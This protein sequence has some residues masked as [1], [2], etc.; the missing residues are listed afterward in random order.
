MVESTVVKPMPPVTFGTGPADTPM[1]TQE[2]L[3]NGS[4]HVPGKVDGAIA[5]DGVPSDSDSDLEDDSALRPQHV[6][7]RRR[8][9]NAIFSAW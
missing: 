3:V 6:T 4:G 2:T 1:A 7:E 9:Q 8:I 5:P